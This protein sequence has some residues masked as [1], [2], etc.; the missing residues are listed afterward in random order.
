MI[1]PK[2][3]EQ[4]NYGTKS[5]HYNDSIEFKVEE[6]ADSLTIKYENLLKRYNNL[7]ILYEKEK[8]KAKIVNTLENDNWILRY[9]NEKLRNTVKD[10][11]Q[12][13]LA[14][15][16]AKSTK[17]AGRKENQDVDTIKR[18]FSLCLEG[19]SLKNICD[20]LNF[21]GIKTKNGGMWGKSS[22]RFILHNDSYVKSGII[23]EETFI[24][25]AKRLKK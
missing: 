16:T 15:T 11:E 19:H 1:K 20:I 2:K 6:S 17:K 25:V 18:I 14:L 13:L 4:N 10:L 23:E 7:E 3:S 5:T 12:K 21:E 8:N 22:I 9:E 24:L